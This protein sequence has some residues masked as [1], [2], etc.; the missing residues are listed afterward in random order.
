MLLG[1]CFRGLRQIG[2]SSREVLDRGLVLT[3]NDLRQVITGQDQDLDNSERDGVNPQ[4][5]TVD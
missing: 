4:R 1:Y 2:N 3:V 5:T